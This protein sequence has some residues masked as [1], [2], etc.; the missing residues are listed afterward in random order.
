MRRELGYIRTSGRAKQLVI[1]LVLVISLAALTG[2]D[3]TQPAPTLVPTLSLPTPTVTPSPVPTI[4]DP[5]A[6]AFATGFPTWRTTTIQDHQ[7][8]DFRQETAGALTEGDLYYSAFSP[9]QGT[10]C[11]WGDNVAQVGGRDLGSW[12][13]TEL[14]EQPLPRDR[15][16]GQCI[17]VVR[18]HVYVYGIRGDERL[19]VFRVVDTGPDWV[20]L[21]YILRE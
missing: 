1:W 16:S 2:C 7:S 21:E 20:T 19:A 8:Y 17:A 12:S 5:T 18:G 14:T 6:T 9:R 10:A 11:F 15:Y 3:A 13:L 4:A